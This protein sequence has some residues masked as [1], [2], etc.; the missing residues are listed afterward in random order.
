MAAQTHSWTQP[1]T[2][3]G[4]T[5]QEALRDHL[6]LSNRQAKALID[7]RDVFVNGKRLWMARHLLKPGD[8]I[9]V[10]TREESRTDSLTILYQDP[11]LLAVNKAPGLLSDGGKDS[12]E[13]LLRT[14]ESQPTL[15]ALHRLDRDTSGVLLLNLQET[16]REPYVEMFR[17]HHLQKQYLALV[18]G[19]PDTARF[20][21]DT[22][23]DGK[24]AVTRVQV[25]SKNRAYALLA[26][27]IPTGRTHQIRRHLAQ[28]QL[29]IAGDRTYGT[30]ESPPPV[31]RGIPR[32]LLHAW[33]VRMPCPHTL[34]EIRITAPPPP[35]FTAW[36]H[37]LGLKL[38]QEPVSS[39]S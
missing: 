2:L 27:E 24:E 16:E 26:C 8:K 23:L 37:K 29:F 36:C 18:R 39:P 3:H 28:R 17:Q 32:Q 19:T 12:V 5:L 25:L 4:Q 1:R 7:A 14:R 11:W 9:E 6:Q 21:V 20:V 31:E 30:H 15:R 22:R 38:P 35:D 34:K 10:L 13:A 33:K